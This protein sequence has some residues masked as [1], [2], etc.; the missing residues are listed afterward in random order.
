[1]TS[2]FNLCESIYSFAIEHVLNIQ[3]LSKIIKIT[4]IKSLY[5]INVIVAVFIV[6]WASLVEGW[7]CYVDVAS[8]EFFCAATVVA[9]SSRTVANIWGHL[10]RVITFHLFL[11]P[12][13]CCYHVVWFFCHSN[14]FCI[15]SLIVANVPSLINGRSLATV[16]AIVILRAWSS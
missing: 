13:I 11:E 8:C 12:S 9:V 3:F 1:M 10:H 15:Y 16:D 2:F 4:W 14:F 7:W 6:I 5:G